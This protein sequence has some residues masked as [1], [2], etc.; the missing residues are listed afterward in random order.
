MTKLKNYI[1]NFTDIQI[2]FVPIFVIFLVIYTWF[3]NRHIKRYLRV[4]KIQIRYLLKKEYYEICS[5][6]H[7]NR[8]LS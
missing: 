3:V 1:T 4:A 8:L 5:S 2:L 6:S 7:L